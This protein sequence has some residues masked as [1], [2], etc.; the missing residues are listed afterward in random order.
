MSYIPLGFRGPQ[1]G[2]ADLTGRNTGNWTVT[3]TPNDL[4][5]NVPFFEIYKIVVS[6][7]SGSTFNVYVDIAQW[8]TAIYGAQ[9]AWD[10][11]QPLLMKPGENLYFFYSD[12]VSDATPPIVTIWLRYDPDIQPAGM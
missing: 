11:N 4:N 6:G 8:D 1:K 10:P 7:A 12:P 5:V 2:A 9:N 3:F